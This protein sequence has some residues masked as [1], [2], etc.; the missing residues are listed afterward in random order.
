M[1]S[2]SGSNRPPKRETRQ[3][4]RTAARK[5]LMIQALLRS[6]VFTVQKASE[7]ANVPTTTHYDWVRDDKDYAEAVLAA[8]EVQT[9]RLEQSVEE[10]ARGMGVKAPSDVLSIF[11]LN[12]KR[13][14]K[15]RPKTKVELSGG[16]SV[17]EL[18]LSPEDP[19]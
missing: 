9:Q 6:D 15:Y 14:E 1:D 19:T 8:E 17:K 3:E 18:L 2:P 13:P 12:A 5:R 10:R 4:I 16:V 7:V 11:L